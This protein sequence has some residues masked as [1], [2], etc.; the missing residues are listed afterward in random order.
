MTGKQPCNPTYI[1]LIRHAI[2][3][4][5]CLFRR[6]EIQCNASIRVASH[7]LDN[8]LINQNS[9]QSPSYHSIIV[10]V[11]EGTLI[12]TSLAPQEETAYTHKS[13]NF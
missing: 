12:S 8:C 9:Q 4:V 1:S 10:T 11:K 2:T 3:S 7:S 13:T 6:A 5:R